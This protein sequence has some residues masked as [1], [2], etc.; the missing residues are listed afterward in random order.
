MRHVSLPATFGIALLAGAAAPAFGAAPDFRRDV[1][2]VLQAHCLKCHGDGAKKG[3]LDLR[4]PALMLQGGTT[5]PAVV[6]G[7][8][9]KSL[10]IEQVTQG[11]MPPGR[12]AK[13]SGGQVATLRAWVDAGAPGGGEEPPAFLVSLQDRQFW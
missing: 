1:L 2:P 10:L 3:G 12:A 11:R 7:N 4:S 13:L 9:A 5:G 6:A 8:S